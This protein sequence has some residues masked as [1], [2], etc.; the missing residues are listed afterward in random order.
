V[1]GRR[2]LLLPPPSTSFTG[3]GFSCSG[4]ACITNSGL[5]GLAAG[6]SY[7]CT[8]QAVN[9]VG[10]SSYSIASSPYIIAAIPD[11]PTNAE[12]D[13]YNAVPIVGVKWTIPVSNGGSTINAYDILCTPSPSG[14]PVFAS[15]VQYS[16]SNPYCVGN[17]GGLS[18]C[19]DYTCQIRAVNTAGYQSSYSG[20]SDQFLISI[21][22]PP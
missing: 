13:S 16:C 21:S 11:A 6:L 8:V 15:N 17:I 4:S 20:P 2:R 1:I 12:F 18:T 10:P 7:T 9:S 19:V 14:S 5:T 3:V 22:C